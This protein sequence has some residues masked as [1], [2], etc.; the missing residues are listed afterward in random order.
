MRFWA[1]ANRPEMVSKHGKNIVG[2]NRD[3]TSMPYG[4]DQSVL[5]RPDGS[6]AEQ[7]VVGGD[8]R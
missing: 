2:Q 5:H 8:Q 3:V 1:W 7:P 4:A 6:E